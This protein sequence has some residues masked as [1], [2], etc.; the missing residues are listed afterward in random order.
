MKANVN[1]CYPMPRYVG[2]NVSDKTHILFDLDKGCQMT[3]VPVN[4]TQVDDTRTPE[5]GPF[6]V[7]GLKAACFRHVYRLIVARFGYTA[8]TA[9]KIVQSAHTMVENG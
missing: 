4:T 7:D 6:N 1:L 8:E 2:V 3:V 9:L 5:Y